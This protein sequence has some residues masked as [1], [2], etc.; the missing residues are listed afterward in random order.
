MF[1]RQVLN[2]PRIDLVA[3]ALRKPGQTI[4]WSG[5]E[6]SLLMQQA[7]ASGLLA[8]VAA[9]QESNLEAQQ[10]LPASVAAHMA[11]AQRVCQAQH[12]EIHREVGHLQRALA[13][14]DAP[15]VLLKGAAYVMAGLPAARGRVFSDI[16]IM[17]PKRVIAQ[18]ESMLAMHGW[19]S[20]Q[21]SGYYQRYYRE[22]MHELPPMH[23]VQRGTVQ[24]NGSQQRVVGNPNQLD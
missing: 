13:G 19:M 24:Q 16:D 1:G 5:R 15:V 7:R 14:L 10:A 23:H 21:H 18:A 8:R 22:W 3:E 17:V 20:N 9:G 4:R 2:P 12:N 6:W 11:A